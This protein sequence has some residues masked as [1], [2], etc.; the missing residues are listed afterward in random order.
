MKQVFEYI[1]QLKANPLCDALLQEIEFQPLTSYPP[2]KE[3]VLF[4]RQVIR[5]LYQR[6]SHDDNQL[7]LR[8]LEQ[9]INYCKY[10]N[11]CSE[12]LLQLL[13]ML[14]TLRQPNDLKLLYDAKFNLSYNIS[15]TIDINLLFGL[16]RQAIFALDANLRSYVEEKQVIDPEEFYLVQ[17]NKW[18][19]DLITH[20][21][22][23]TVTPAHT[24]ATNTSKPVFA[25]G[26]V[27]SFRFTNNHQGALIV[28][29][30]YE[31]RQGTNY[32][33]YPTSLYQVSDHY[34]IDN[35]QVY[36]SKT[37][38]TWVKKMLAT[39]E[40]P[41]APLLICMPISL[42]GM[43]RFGKQF[44]KTASVSP[45]I[46]PDIHY[47]SPISYWQSFEMRMKNII[48]G[49]YFRFEAVHL[50]NL[51]RSHSN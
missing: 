44:K 1:A 39:T 3:Q 41:P 10:A 51:T 45:I 19:Q 20:L 12:N 17:K 2:Q 37:K 40:P 47:L 27:L 25:P 22:N 24:Q 15:Q 32:M 23:P 4:R 14:Y 35:L 18:D 36:R 34:D 28:A 7:I 49:L 43:S 46:Y 31:N 9:E 48:E 30:S 11:H 5:A 8:L 38:T 13:F 33:V 21:I 16:G 42:A 26:D 6:Y 29:S 50:K